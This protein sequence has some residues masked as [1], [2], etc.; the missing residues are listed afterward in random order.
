MGWGGASSREDVEAQINHPVS[1]DVLCS[2]DDVFRAHP[3]APR[4]VELDCLTVGTTPRPDQSAGRELQ[5]CRRDGTSCRSSAHVGRIRRRTSKSGS[6]SFLQV[7]RTRGF[8][9]RPLE[10]QVRRQTLA[11]ALARNYRLIDSLDSILGPAQRE[12]AEEEVELLKS[13]T[14]TGFEGSDRKR[15]IQ[16]RKGWRCFHV[17]SSLSRIF[18]KSNV[19]RL[20]MQ[21]CIEVT[22]TL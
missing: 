11:R 8:I 5:V 16:R 17:V 21:E 14:L 6:S 2:S 15:L 12:S 18:H 10:D 3:A 13:L 22:R 9:H 4:N 7:S 20:N 1:V 19:S